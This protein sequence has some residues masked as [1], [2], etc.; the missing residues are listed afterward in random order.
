MRLNRERKVL[1]VMMVL[2]YGC[3]FLADVSV[4][5]ALGC[6]MIALIL[7][8][9]LLLQHCKITIGRWSIGKHRP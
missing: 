1:L 6:I 8:V 4:Y 9:W 3:M 7:N 5:A 2:V